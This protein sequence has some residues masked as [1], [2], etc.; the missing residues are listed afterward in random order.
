MIHPFEAIWRQREIV[1]LDGGLATELEKRG[2]NL[3][4]PLWSAKVLLE[5]PTLIQEVHEDY[6]RAGADVIT[7][8]SYQATLPGLMAK[9]LSSTESRELLQLSV[10]LAKAA[11]EKYQG[12][13]N[14]P[15]PLRIAGSVGC[16][17]AFL[18]DGSEYRGD[19]GLTRRQL[20]DWHRPRVEILVEAGVDVLAF[21]T[22]P[23]LAEVEGIIELLEK[24]P[25]TPA[26]I[27]MSCKD[28]RD[29]WHG[30]RFAHAVALVQ[31]VANVVAVGVNCTA[32]NWIDG[33]LQS[34]GAPGKT[35]LIVYP[36]QGEGWNPMEKRWVPPQASCDWPVA[37]RRWFEHGARIVGGCCRTAPNTIRTL[38]QTFPRKGLPDEIPGTP[39]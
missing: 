12:E 26:W 15:R 11:R 21:E 4:D 5:Q 25:E 1:I 37:S 16:Y 17:G 7:T 36:N 35:P 27:S 8:A 30:E 3:N 2:A 22:I 13:T 10:R 20:R 32:P 34:A 33:L 19:Y 39:P 24:M 9:G 31:S 23:C 28:S 14:H 18:H 29:L 38:A 6:L